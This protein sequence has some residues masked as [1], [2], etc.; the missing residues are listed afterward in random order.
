MTNRVKVWRYFEGL[1]IDTNNIVF[2]FKF[3]LG[4][5]STIPED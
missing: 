3:M 4:I 5:E 1:S 2:E